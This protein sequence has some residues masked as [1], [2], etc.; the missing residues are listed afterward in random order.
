MIDTRLRT[1]RP[2]IGGFA[3]QYKGWRWTQWCMLFIT[4]AVYLIAVPMRETYKPIILARRAK[5]L[6]LT[7]RET[8]NSG[9]K[10]SLN[11]NFLRPLHMLFT[12]PV[13]F[14]FSLYTAFAFGVLFLYFAAFPYVFQRPPYSFTVSQTGLTFLG[15]GF[16]V[17]LAA[18]TGVVI[19]R[20]IYQLQ[21]RKAT[22]KGCAH[23]RPEHR[24]YNAMIGSFGIPIG[25]FWFGW[26]ANEGKHWAVLCVAAVPFAWGNMC[27]F[28]SL[29]PQ[30]LTIVSLLT[31][32]R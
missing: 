4:L 3:A 21:H 5:K 8:N 17:L 14:F 29:S 18:I 2:I 19:D 12:E 32:M 30:R 31:I 25:L 6:G 24:L 10:S 23:A 16:G 11:Q 13:V 15:I 20:K 1:Y 9:V 26:A 22:A 27:V 7:L 28:V